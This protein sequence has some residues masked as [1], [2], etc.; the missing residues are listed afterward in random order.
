MK[1]VIKRHDGRDISVDSKSIV[2]I[3]WNASAQIIPGATRVDYFGGTAYIDEDCHA[4]VTRVADQVPFV[5]LT[6][7][8]GE[9]V[10]V[11]PDTITG[12]REPLPEEASPGVHAFFFAGGIKQ[13]VRETVD[14]VREAIK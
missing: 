2:R 7:P 12:L 9:P 11:N 3:I 8:D 1:V 4:F 14:Q 5:K 10:W 13:N 6:V